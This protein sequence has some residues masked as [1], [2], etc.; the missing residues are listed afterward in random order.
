MQER[1][2]PEFDEKR[3]PR[4]QRAVTGR[5]GDVALRA[6]PD[7]LIVEDAIPA[8]PVDLAGYSGGAQFVIQC[9]PSGMRRRCGSVV[10]VR[11]DRGTRNGKRTASTARGKGGGQ[12]TSELTPPV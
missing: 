6:L 10:A 9:R 7:A 2:A 11:N 8:G 3:F 5:R 4:F 12:R 1:I